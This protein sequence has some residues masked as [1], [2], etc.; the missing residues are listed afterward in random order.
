METSNHHRTSANAVRI[1]PHRI[2]TRNAAGDHAA[3][4]ATGPITP[5]EPDSRL[6]RVLD[7]EPPGS[8]FRTRVDFELALTHARETDGRWQYAPDRIHIRRVSWAGVDATLV[9]VSS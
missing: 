6:E 5:V 9:G 3:T 2:W 8:V 4:F 1:T 7:G